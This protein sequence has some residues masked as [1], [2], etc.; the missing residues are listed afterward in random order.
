M[1]GENEIVIPI[2]ADITKLIEQ[3]NKLTGD[4]EELKAAGKGAG[5]GIGDGLDKG[6]KKAKELAEALKLVN[7]AIKVQKDPKEKTRLEGEANAIR[8]EI[9]LLKDR[10]EEIDNNTI[11][12][13]SLRT[14]IMEIKNELSLMIENGEEGTQ[15]FNEL[16]DQLGELT[17]RRKDIQ[18]LG[19]VIGSDTRKFETF[20]QAVSG[21]SAVFSVY[22]GV[23]ALVGSENKDFQKT[24]T[25]VMGAMAI[26]NGVQQIANMLQKQSNIYL[27]VNNA[28]NKLSLLYTKQKT[29][30]T[31]VQTAVT[32]GAT[33]A[34]WS[35]NAAMLANP[36]GIVIAALAALTAGVIYFASESAEAAR[37][38]YTFNE[39]LKRMNRYAEEST[40]ATED[41][42]TMMNAMGSSREAIL[43]AEI[44]TL[45]ELRTIDETFVEENRKNYKKLNDEQK[46]EWKDKAANVKKLGREINIKLTELDALT[47]ENGKKA[48]ELK[49][50][51]MADGFNKEKAIIIQKYK[52]DIFAAGSNAEL[53]KQIEAAKEKAISDLKRK[54]GLEN[55]KLENEISKLAADSKLKLMKEGFDKEM[56]T[57]AENYKNQKSDLELRLKEDLK[58]NSSQREKIKQVILELT[59]LQQR[60]ENK[61]IEKY[62][63]KRLEQQIEL[64]QKLRE[65]A[66]KEAKK[67]IDEKI[68]LDEFYA[69]LSVDEKTSLSNQEMQ[70]ESIKNAKLKLE[71]DKW[72]EL[73]R[74][75]DE[76]VFI[77]SEADKKQHEQNIVDITKWSAEEQ[78]KIEKAKQEKRIEYA[79]FAL[80]QITNAIGLITE[81][82]NQKSDENLN[83]ITKN[84]DAQTASFQKLLDQGI[85]TQEQY[86]AKVEQ[87]NK[88]KERK[89]KEQ[90][91]KAWEQSR[92]AQL[93][94][95]IIAGTQASL[96]AYAS[97]AATPLIGTTVGAA[98]ASIAALFA[99]AEIALI[100]GQKNPYR[101]GTA[102]ILGGRSHEQGGVSLGQFGE[103]EKGEFLGILSKRQTSTY[104]N[105]LMNLFE[106]LNK[107]NKDKVLT[108]LTDIASNVGFSDTNTNLSVSLN[109]VKEIKNIEKILKRNGVSVT[110]H[111]GFREEKT[112]GNIK[113]I[114]G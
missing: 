24:M 87:L 34:Q 75:S 83:K 26:A 25:K 4:V 96:A 16:A 28:F 42:V 48:I 54:Y 99:A 107:N 20:A 44:A 27:A 89:E 78:L 43:K 113:R 70:I 66:R 11:K 114:Y 52:D 19:D 17:D 86:D 35:L 112:S 12:Y 108:G 97:G 32:G 79:Q 76:E 23:M 68:A 31:V 33:A 84:Y 101:K 2:S 53:I 38:Q 39:E 62:A 47:L 30:A 109:E 98:Y 59:E 18:Q 94:N 10:G 8:K 60:D 9:E 29:A 72:N 15:K 104:G 56:A 22:Q 77:I 65:S 41:L 1:A 71:N 102:Q 80:T 5:S 67:L 21:V 63:N 6:T 40:N 82:Q 3:I 49:L 58:L 45:K 14:Q 93:I 85:I 51:N 37:V 74:K 50:Q 100:A 36:I 91:R 61:L 57:I 69:G 92:N 81:F 111:S 110:Y 105:G 103:A 64:D 7:Q 73:V 90:K 95:A 55:L 88:D 106:G 13:K 46:Q